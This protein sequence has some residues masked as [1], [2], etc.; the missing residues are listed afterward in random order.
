[1][2]TLSEIKLSVLVPVYNEVKSVENLLEAIFS[3]NRLNMEVIVINDGSNDGTLEALNRFNHGRV[4]I[5]S[6]L[7]NSG[8]GEAIKSGLK[9]ATGEVVLIQDGDLEYNPGDYQKLLALFLTDNVSVVYGTRLNRRHFRRYPVHYLGNKVVT[10]LVNILYGVS[11]NDVCTGYKVFKKDV[12]EK[13]DLRSRRFDFD[14][15]LTSKFIKNNYPIYEIPIS[16]KRRNHRQGKKFG[17]KD[18]IITVYNIF[19]YRFFD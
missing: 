16:Y 14:I 9:L 7:R 1:M 18:R 17:W 6:H 5:V 8:K 3:A 4:K 15:E 13:F 11:L 19:R 2:K 10:G 12:A